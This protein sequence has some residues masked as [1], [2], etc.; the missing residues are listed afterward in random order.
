[1][2]YRPKGARVLVE[3]IIQTLSLEERAARAGLEIVVESENKPK[4]T[5][6]KIVALGSDP[7]AHEEYKVGDVVFFKW[8]SGTKITLQDREYRSLELQEIEGVEDTI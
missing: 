4:C 1:M 6:G 8:H 7:L 5:M 2:A 3:D